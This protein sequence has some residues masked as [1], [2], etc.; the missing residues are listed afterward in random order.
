MRIKYLFLS[1]MLSLSAT[2]N[3]TAQDE[4]L[5]NFG[6]LTRFDYQR[7]YID[8][9]PLR[10]NSGFKGKNLS[11]YFNGDLTHV[12][13]TSTGSVRT[14]RTRMSLFSMLLISFI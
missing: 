11:I 2:W 10:E 9:S 13:P 6:V 7:E 3:V 5:L 1:I 8:G 4:T 12:C 14:G